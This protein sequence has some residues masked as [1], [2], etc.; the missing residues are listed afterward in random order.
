MAR[1]KQGRR[2]TEEHRLFQTRLSLELQELVRLIFLALFDWDDINKSTVK[3][4]QAVVPSVVEY[5]HKSRQASID[6][7]K[8]FEQYEAPR[9]VKKEIKRLSLELDEQEKQEP[10]SLDDVDTA[11]DELQ[12]LED[13]LVAKVD[14]VS[15]RVADPDPFET[16][17]VDDRD[18]EKLPLSHLD[19]Q[20]DPVTEDDL[21]SH[22]ITAGRDAAYE[23]A[24]RKKDRQTGTQHTLNRVVGEAST[25]AQEGGRSAISR[26]VRRGMGPKGYARVPDADP[27]AF[28]A[29]LAAFGAMGA[30]RSDAF[31][32]SSR[33]KKGSMKPDGSP[34]ARSGFEVH[35]Y[36]CC[37]LE[38]VYVI[39]GQ[40]QLP[41]NGKQLAKEW[42]EITAGLGGTGSKRYHTTKKGEKI[43]YGRQEA[44]LAWR[45][46]R[47]RGVLPDTYDGPLQGKRRRNKPATGQPD[48]VKDVEVQR[49]ETPDTWTKEDYK[50]QY[51][52][53]K[54]RVE[55]IELEIQERLE[56]GQD[57][58]DPSL[59]SLKSQ[60]R[61]CKKYRDRYKE[62][63]DTN[64]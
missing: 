17:G 27:C 36:C 40:Y 43:D 13:E 54:E 63:L 16:R 12:K 29:L 45:R 31:K 8:L 22:L 30:Y 23:S 48:G 32:K 53:F 41:G 2:L 57:E 50:E 25:L 33:N 56:S 49:P 61:A 28:C 34:G 5:R 46:W 6:Y 64:A 20:Y 1:T 55:G 4:A 21:M 35:D 14:K 19:L 10:I 7:L 58:N 59:L 26:Y 11:W 38:P 24:K 15:A 52:G 37:T 39:D 44:Y 51:E 47:E 62:W 3:V 18:L 60:L 42:A 9:Q